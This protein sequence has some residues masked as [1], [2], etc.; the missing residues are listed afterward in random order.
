[1]IRNDC[2]ILLC[3]CDAYSD[4]WEPF[5]KLL[6]KFGDNCPYRIQLN[7]ESAKYDYDGF[8]IQCL[9][10]YTN[11]QVSYGERMLATMPTLKE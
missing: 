2:T 7:T 10:K 9:Q 8:E 4:C 5:F 6:K 1:M 3:S 11:G